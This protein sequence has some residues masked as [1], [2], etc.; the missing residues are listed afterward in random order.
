M[1]NKHFK[2]WTKADMIRV[3]DLIKRGISVARTAV[4]MERSDAATKACWNTMRRVD[5]INSGSD[6]D[7]IVS[8]T[9]REA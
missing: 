4:I 8:F 3:A 9:K 5:L 1:K 2:P 7:T 6:E